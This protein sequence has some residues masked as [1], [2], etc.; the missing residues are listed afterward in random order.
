MGGFPAARLTDPTVH[1]GLISVGCP[2]VLIGNQP[3]A[4][5]G[6]MHTCPMLTG[7]VPHVGGPLVLGSFTVIVGGVPQSRVNDMLICVGPPD[8]VLIGEPTV[9]VGNAGSAGGFGAV[10]GAML[11]GLKNFVGGSPKAVLQPDGS[12]ATEYTPT[13]RLTG[14][15]LEQAKNIQQL[16]SIRRGAGGDEFLDALGSANHPV[17]IHVIGDP[18]QGRT[19]YPGKQ[20]HENCAVQSAQ[21]IIHQASGNSYSESQMEAIAN[22]PAPSGYTRNGGTPPGGEQTIL[23]NGGVPAHM[24]PGTTQNI[25]HALQGGRG[26]ISGHDAGALWDDPNYAGSGHDV[27]TIGAVQDDQG[28]TLGYIIND[29]GAGQAGRTVP[30]ADYAGSLD[31]GPIAVT[32]NPIW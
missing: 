6:D 12:Y 18:A 27:N 15:P 13:T 1:G 31:G 7:V 20:H 19:L 21:Q 17:T 25:D 23:S 11:A 10:L 3:A 26:V 4:R 9:L 5:I 29:T 22:S 30:A 2:T 24:E 32:D 28:K 14:S 8:T 16:D